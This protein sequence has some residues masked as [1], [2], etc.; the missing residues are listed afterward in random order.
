[1]VTLI[2]KIISDVYL[3]GLSRFFSI[4]AKQSG[5]TRMNFY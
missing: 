5:Y 3:N 1:V 4:V 2:S